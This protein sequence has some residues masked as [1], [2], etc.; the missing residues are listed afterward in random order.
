MVIQVL[1]EWPPGFEELNELPM[2]WPVFGV[3]LF[4]VLMCS[5]SAIL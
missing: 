1:L 2:N 3:T 5:V 4:T